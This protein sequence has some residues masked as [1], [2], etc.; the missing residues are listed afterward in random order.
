MCGEA[1]AIVKAVEAG[2][3]VVVWQAVWQAVGR[4]GRHAVRR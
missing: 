3:E 2:G 1:V 4:H